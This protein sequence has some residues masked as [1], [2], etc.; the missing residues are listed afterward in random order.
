MVYSAPIPASIAGDFS[1]RPR[2]GISVTLAPSAAGNRPRLSSGGEVI[3][4]MYVASL[5]FIRSLVGDKSGNFSPKRPRCSLLLKLPQ[6]EDVCELL[7]EEKWMTYFSNQG[8]VKSSSN[9][10]LPERLI[11]SRSTSGYRLR[12]RISLCCRIAFVIGAPYGTMNEFVLRRLWILER[13]SYISHW[14]SLNDAADRLPSLLPIWSSLWLAQLM[15]NDI[16][17]NR[18]SFRTPHLRKAGVTAIS[19]ITEFCL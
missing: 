16:T 8:G 6:G 19:Y 3:S 15:V 14:S 9:L 1:S 5:R 18:M 2:H 12:R 7:D 13:P 11:G 4:A 10:W 17:E